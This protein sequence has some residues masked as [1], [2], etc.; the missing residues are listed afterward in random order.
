MEKNS[1]KSEKHLLNLSKSKSIKNND[2]INKNII[3][4][5]HPKMSLNYLQYRDQEYLVPPA[6]HQINNGIID[7]NMQEISLYMIYEKISNV[8]N[9]MKLQLKSKKSKRKNYLRSCCCLQPFKNKSDKNLERTSSDINNNSN[10]PFNYDR[11]NIN[12]HPCKTFSATTISPWPYSPSQHSLP[13]ISSN[14]TK[15]SHDNCKNDE[16]NFLKLELSRTLEH[17]NQISLKIDDLKELIINKP[18]LTLST[19]ENKS[20]LAAQDDVKTE[21]KI[22]QGHDELIPGEESTI[23][24]P[25]C[26]HRCLYC[27]KCFEIEET[28]LKNNT[29]ET[30][31]INGCGFFENCRQS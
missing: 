23:R 11:F 18:N 28:I 22:F 31:E 6:A 9:M 1:S 14:N 3:S 13:P 2:E 30:I 4:F 15:Q 27:L 21:Q 19:M 8:E 20:E 24:C 26:C 10:D 17:I 16:M 5:V 29:E 7:E 25:D 12:V